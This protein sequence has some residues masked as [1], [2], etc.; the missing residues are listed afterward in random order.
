MKKLFLILFVVVAI[1]GCKKVKLDE[2][3]LTPDINSFLPDSVLT[4]MQSLGMVINT[5]NRPPKFEGDE[6]IVAPFE[7]K[8][9]NIPSDVIGRTFAN[10]YIKFYEFDKKNLTVKVDY[11]NGPEYGTA[12]GS[13]VVGTGDNFSVF[14]EMTASISASDSAKLT[15]VFSGTL[16]SDGIEDFYYANFMLNN[17]GNVSGYWIENGQGRIAFDSDGISEISDAKSLIVNELKG[18]SAK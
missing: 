5:G 11:V 15:M 12:L 1:M 2:N 17:Y 3:G 10:L 16:K 18:V 9:S 6:Y 13:Y 14:V 7:L 8:N 4:E